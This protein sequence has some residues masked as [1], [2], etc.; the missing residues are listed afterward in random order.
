MS[1][2]QTRY[3]YPN[4]F[5]VGYPCGRGRRGWEGRG[6][7]SQKGIPSQN[8]Y[9]QAFYYGDAMNID[10]NIR[11][12]FRSSPYFDACEN[13][14]EKWDQTS[15]DPGAKFKNTILKIFLKGHKQTVPKV[16]LT[17]IQITSCPNL[18]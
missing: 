16:D 1:P 13:F 3:I 7:G 17:F 10:K 6:G 8:D 9:F 2:P 15:F 11:E 4:V 18:Q 5:S 14:C 12:R